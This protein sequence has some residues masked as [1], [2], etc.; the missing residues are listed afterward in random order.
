MRKIGFVVVFL[1]LTMMAVSV[2]AE[3][4]DYEENGF[5]YRVKRKEAVVTGTE[6]SDGQLNIPGTLGGFP[7]TKIDY[8]AFRKSGFTEVS[9]P[10]TVT[11]IDDRAFMNAK[12]LKSIRLP[13]NLKS[14]GRYAFS[15]C[16]ALSSVSLSKKMTVLE[17]GAFKNCISLK[18]ITLPDSIVVIGE[19]TFENCYKLTNIK[20]SKKLRSIDNYAFYHDYALKSVAI[21]SKVTSVGRYAFYSC[22]DLT[23]VRFASAKTKLGDGVFSRCTSLKKAILPKKIKNVPES[24]FENCSKLSKVT[25]PKT[26]SIIKKK[27]FSNCRSLKGI[28]LNTK[29]YAIGDRAFAGSGLRKIKMNANMQFIGNGA[30]QGT[31]IQSIALKSK[32]T[33]IG[34]KVFANCGKLKRVSIPSSVKGINPGAFNNCVSLQEIN[35]AS[36]NANYCSEAGV[37]YNKSKTK[38]IQYP[39][40]KTSSSFRTP[41]SLE[42]IRS[43]AFAGNRYLRSVTISAGSI[44]KYAF[45]E[46]NNLRSVTILSG[47]GK[48]ESGAFYWNRKLTQITLPDSVTSI[49]SRA[50]A[51]TKVRTIH[52]PSRL[53]SLR[54]DAFDD[55]NN[56]A[57]FT[58]GSGGNYRVQEG[59]LYNRSL[60]TLIKYPAKKTTKVFTV[61]DSVKE[62]KSWAFEN[63][64][65]LT[66]LYFGANF[67]YLDYNAIYN[68][69]NLKSIVFNSK[70]LGYGSSSGVSSCDRLAVIVG[71]NTYTM[72]S[73]ASR[74]NATLITL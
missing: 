70:K 42:R 52:I 6:L 20:L 63:A 27:A 65:Y 35:V 46:M 26:V 64:A 60:T 47:T 33:F 29:A 67:R 45:S 24:A 69:K 30:F 34:N 7:V 43:N 54:R 57:Y 9:I 71:P 58:G 19:S 21:P 25:L 51:K 23:T 17:D 2:P 16:T 13:G 28:T 55:C 56:L 41:G 5:S 62:V 3:A 59:V 31:N 37:L 40:H 32:V 50:F 36:G 74:A 49:G 44:G 72:R 48:I 18:K 61:P 14:L 22:S 8:G 73:M 12:K 53:V 38:L 11:E 68:A 15:G 4:K 1:F 39:L 66:K 10:A